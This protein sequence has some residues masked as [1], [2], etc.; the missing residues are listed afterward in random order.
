MSDEARPSRDEARRSLDDVEAARRATA[1]VTRR[2]PWLDAALALV[3]GASV[4]AGLLEQ[5]GVSV[6][7]LLVGSVAVAIA[8]QRRQRR[9]GRILDQR[10]M[11]AR[12]L[13]FMALYLV[14]FLLLQIGPPDDWQPWYALAVGVVAALGGFAWL[15]WDDAYQARRLAAGDFGKYDLL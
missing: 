9:R 2:S 15:R 5:W 14:M 13:P 12:A 4:A 10:A 7:V 1:E 6:G 11:G 3:V 8:T